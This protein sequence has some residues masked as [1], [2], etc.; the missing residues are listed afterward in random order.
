MHFFFNIWGLFRFFNMAGKLYYCH[1]R[2]L[3]ISRPMVPN[4]SQE[5][6]LKRNGRS[7]KK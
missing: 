6:G 4:E 3:L 7:E 5:T 1:A 2:A